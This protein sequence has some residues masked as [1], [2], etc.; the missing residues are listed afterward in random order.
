MK[1]SQISRFIDVIGG[2]LTIKGDKK[3]VLNRLGAKLFEI[4]FSKMMV[5]IYQ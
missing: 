3:S 2:F 4:F 5:I 1:E